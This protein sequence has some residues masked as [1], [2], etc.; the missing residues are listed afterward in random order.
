[1]RPPKATHRSASIFWR[2]SESWS[3]SGRRI[4]MP[5]A[6]PRGMMVALWIGSEPMTCSELLF[7]IAHR[8]GA[9]FR[10]HH[11]L[12]LGV[13]QLAHG[14]DAFAAPSRHQRALI[15]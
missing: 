14:D 8:E 6:R 12:V 10:T 5:S 7:L 4:T 2:V 11:H 1:M 3:R 9:A 13:F 15:H